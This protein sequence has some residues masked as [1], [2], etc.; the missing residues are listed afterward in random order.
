MIVYI[1]I[2]TYKKVNLLFGLVL[3]S[4]GSVFFKQNRA[5]A[6]NVKFEI[7]KF[8][9]MKNELGSHLNYL[10]LSIVQKEKDRS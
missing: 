9:N 2:C 10:L 7:H 5:G 4:P 1:L 6:N 3:T 8:R